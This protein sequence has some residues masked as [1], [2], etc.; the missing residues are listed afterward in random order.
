[1]LIVLLFVGY[2]FYSSSSK[3][4]LLFLL[5]LFYTGLSVL[6]YA[7]SAVLSVLASWFLGVMG[8]SE[9]IVVLVIVV[10]CAALLGMSTAVVNYLLV[11][12]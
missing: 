1:M 10:T 6:G 8:E 12:V 4:C 9:L 11:R 5:S 7:I 2:V 3:L